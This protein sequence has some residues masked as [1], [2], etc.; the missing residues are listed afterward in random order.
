MAVLE[1]VSDVEVV[2]G[3]DANEDEALG[4]GVEVDWASSAGESTTITGELLRPPD[5]AWTLAEPDR[6]LKLYAPFCFWSEQRVRLI[7]GLT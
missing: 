7:W 2:D 5:P 4:A 6:M 1:T 3:L